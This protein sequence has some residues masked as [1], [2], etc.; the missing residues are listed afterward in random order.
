[1]M[2]RKKGKRRGMKNIG[3]DIR[4]DM[5]NWAISTVLE[6]AL[7]LADNLINSFP[8]LQEDILEIREK[9]NEQLAQFS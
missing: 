2:Y 7:S 8:D 9:I 5:D 3:W 1:M 6:E 4:G